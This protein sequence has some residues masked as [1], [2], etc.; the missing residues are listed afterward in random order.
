MYY[1]NNNL[2]ST[3]NL[4]EI[5]KK[6]NCKNFVFSSSATVYG[7][8]KAPFDENMVTGVGL[9]NPYGKTKY[10]QEEMLKDLYVSDNTWNIVILRYFN[11]I[12]QKNISLAEKPSGI[13]NNIFPYIVKVHNKELTKLQVYGND[14]ETPDGTCVRDFIHVVDLANAHI[15]ACEYIINN[16]NVELK[17]YNL[18]TGVGISVQQL[19]DSFEKINNAKLNYTYVNRRCGDID[20][21][22][23]DS[24]LANTELNWVAKYNINDMVML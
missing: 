19:I 10:M 5:M 2:I 16:K 8:N 20:I 1:Y 13:P 6:Y 24:T 12:S 18:G 17:I 3:I 9:T 7:N 15:K 11:P 22:Y 14:Y 23:S 21:S 4:I